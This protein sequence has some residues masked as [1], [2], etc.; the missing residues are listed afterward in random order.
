MVDG[1]AIAYLSKEMEAPTGTL[2]ESLITAG[3]KS[4]MSY[5]KESLPSFLFLISLAFVLLAWMLS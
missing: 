5:T 1:N 4:Q 3:L 2:F